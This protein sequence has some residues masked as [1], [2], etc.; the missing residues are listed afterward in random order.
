MKCLSTISLTE[1]IGNEIYKCAN[2]EVNM[3]NGGTENRA[4]IRINGYYG[5]KVIVISCVSAFQSTFDPNASLTKRKGT[6]VLP[7]GFTI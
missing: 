4:P 2:R 3:K 6:T 7:C 5:V 1:L